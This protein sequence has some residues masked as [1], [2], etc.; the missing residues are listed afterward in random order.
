MRRLLPLLL[1][2]A[3]TAA[4]ADGFYY[5]ESFGGV[6][7]KDE[8]SAYMSDGLRIRLAIGMRHQ[9]WAVEAFFAGNIDDHTTVRADRAEA[10]ELDTYGVDIK[11]LQPVARHLEVYLRGSISA[12]VVD[13]TLDGYVHGPL[14]GYAGR[15]LGMGAGIQLKG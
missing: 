8:L 14:G 2:L 13:S 5:S 4:R 7:V 11:Y 15:G 12:A 6:K 3:P 10:T 9:N 1:V